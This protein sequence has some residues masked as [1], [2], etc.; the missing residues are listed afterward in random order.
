LRSAWMRKQ[1]RE[2]VRVRNA[3]LLVDEASDLVTHIEAEVELGRAQ[4]R[5]VL[6]HLGEEPP[7]L[8]DYRRP[9]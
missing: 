5:I 1:G 7:G 9:W 4:R 8:V 3:F 6:D 2:R